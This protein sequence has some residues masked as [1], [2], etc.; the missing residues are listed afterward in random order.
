MH[1]TVREAQALQMLKSGKMDAEIA[2]EM[3]ISVNTLK[4]HL[5]SLYKKLSVRNRVEAI[6][7]EL[8]K[9]TGER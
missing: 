9:T 3:G 2:T 6:Q 1:L 8:L 5:K 4:S 7:S